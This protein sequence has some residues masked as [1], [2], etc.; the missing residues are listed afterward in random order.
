MQNRENYEVEIWGIYLSTSMFVEDKGTLH[1]F[2]VNDCIR[3]L[4]YF[5]L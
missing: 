2:I 3:V 1:Q 4:C 5:N